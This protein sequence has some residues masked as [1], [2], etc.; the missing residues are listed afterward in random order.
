MSGT[1]SSFF[2]LETYLFVSVINCMIQLDTRE[3]WNKM[4]RG[5]VPCERKYIGS[6]SMYRHTNVLVIVINVHIFLI[7]ALLITDNKM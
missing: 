7:L 5:E 4:S 6:H 1:L 2:L 3:K